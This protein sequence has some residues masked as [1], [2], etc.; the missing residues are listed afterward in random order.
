MKARMMFPMLAISA[1][2]L[3]AC[4][5]GSGGGGSGGGG[6]VASGGI[7]GTSAGAEVRWAMQRR[8]D[9][10]TEQSLQDYILHTAVTQ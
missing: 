3:T 2:V 4:G 8:V 10:A 7:G 1:A 5:G 6:D 9:A